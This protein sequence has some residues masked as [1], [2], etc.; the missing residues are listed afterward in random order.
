MFVCIVRLD[1]CQ[2]GKRARACRRLAGAPPHQAAPAP[3]P[4][5][6]TPGRLGRTVL[7][8]NNDNN[9]RLFDAATLAPR[10]RV[11]FPW[12]AN[13][14]SLRPEAG[15]APGG[16][17]LAAV[18]GDDPVVHLVD[19][20]SGREAGKLAGHKDFAFAAAWHPGGRFLATGNQVRRGSVCVWEGGKLAGHK[21]FCV[22]DRQ[23]G[24]GAARGR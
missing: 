10:A 5:T 8:A 11:A 23:P 7:T 1:L 24:A 22:C 21:D 13:F 4:Q 3:L 2:G 9:V 15:G 14:A 17:S 20:L 6:P 16:G 19:L 18:V 12:A